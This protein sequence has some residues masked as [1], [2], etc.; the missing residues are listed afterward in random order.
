MRNKR[1]LLVILA[2]MV[3]AGCGPS[4]FVIRAVPNDQRLRETELRAQSDRG[5]LIMDKV[6]IID[7]D[8]LIS[9]HQ[10]GGILCQGENPASLFL[11][12][13]QMAQRD[14]A[15]KAVVVRLNSPGG[16]VA[17]SDIMYH[18]LRDF[19]RSG[20]PVVACML[21]V[22]ASGAYYLAC[23]CDG[24]M[25]PPTTV[26]GSIGTIMQTVSFAGTMNKLGI[27][28]QAI[29][30]REFKDLGSPLHDLRPEEREILQGIITKFYQDF[31]NV[32]L[33]GRPGLTR[34]QLL[35]LADGRVF[36]AD[37]AQQAGLIDRIGYPADAVAWAKQMADVRRAK[38]VIYGRP[39][40]HKPTVYSSAGAAEVTSLV[41]VQ[42]PQWLRSEGPQFLYLWAPLAN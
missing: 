42:L 17:G 33:A 34:D 4:A 29:K 40:G 10:P 16:T 39:I 27:K 12:K 1:V 8:G 21:D 28:A 5:F 37:A 31:L 11:E 15:V 7:V 25:A 26:T 35:E 32:V 36:T 14:Q 19:Q 41:N 30:S 18:A 2:G 3:L 6:A 13:L 23:A 20:K 9:N 22:A 38:V 24:I